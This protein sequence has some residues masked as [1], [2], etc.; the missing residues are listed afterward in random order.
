M[1]AWKKKLR[2]R[3]GA[4]IERGGQHEQMITLALSKGRIF[5]ESLPLLRARGI[6]VAEDP[7]E[8]P[9]ADLRDQPARR[10]GGA[11][12]ATDV[13]TYVQY[14]GADL[15]VAGLES[16]LEHSDAGIYARST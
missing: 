3:S 15:G 8:E 14:G 4:D 13:P 6:E 12:R 11:V 1:S 16:L 7:G 9:Q 10:A 2:A 5:D